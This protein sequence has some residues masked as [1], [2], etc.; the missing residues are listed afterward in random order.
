MC[1]SEARLA[2]WGRR[3]WNR[4]RESRAF[5]QLERGLSSLSRRRRSLSGLRTEP[6]VTGRVEMRGRCGKYRSFLDLGLGF[7]YKR[8]LRKVGLVIFF[9]QV[10]RQR[11]LV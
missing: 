8:R 1:S 4:T 6:L 3:G 5:G 9:D 2:S 7:I 10:S 11:S